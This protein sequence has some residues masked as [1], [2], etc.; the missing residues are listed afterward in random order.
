ML[1]LGCVAGAAACS[2]QHSTARPAPKSARVCPAKL[3]GKPPMPQ[4][5]AAQNTLAYWLRRYSPRELDETIL[6]PEDVARYDAAIGRRPGHEVYSQRD[7][8]VPVD[9]LL[10]ASDVRERLTQMQPLLAKHELVDATGQPLSQPQL[11]AFA[12]PMPPLHTSLRVVLAPAAM[13]CGPFDGSLYK[14][15]IEPAYDK[16]ACGTLQA[17]EVVELL[18]AN[19]GGLQLA[20]SRYSLGFLAADAKLSPAVPED[21]IDALVHG[22]RLYA[23]QDT[24]VSTRVAAALT[25]P[26]HATLPLLPSGQALLA[27]ASGFLR[28]AAP[29][30]LAATKRPLTRRA[31]LTAA[32]LFA[33]SPYGLGGARAGRDCSG[34]LVDIF[35]TFDL[36][37]PRYSG[38]QAEAGSYAVNLSGATET[39]KLRRLDLTAR[40]GVVLLHLPGH[41]MLYL[42]RSEAGVPMALHA[43]GD[44]AQPCDGGGESV[45][46]VQRTVVSTLDV[47][48]GSSRTAF[49]ERLDRLVVFARQPP[50]EL[51]AYLLPRPQ[52][53]AAPPA[54]A[55]QCKDDAETR[56][57]ITPALP[58]QG[59]P[60]RVIVTSSV[61]HPEALLQLYDASGAAVPIDETRLGGGGPPVTLVARLAKPLAGRY[62]AVLGYADTVLACRR[63]LLHETPLAEPKAR[64]TDP[65]WEPRWRWERD[66]E[67]LWSAFVEQLFMGPA[68]DEQTWTNLQSLLR[69]PSRNLLH[70]HLGLGEDD[71]LVIEPDCADLPYALRAYFA[72]KLKLP[73]AFRRCSRG[74]T[75]QPPTC[76]ELSSTFAERGE[77]DAVAAFDRFVNR[78][79]RSGVHSATGRTHPNDSATDLYPVAL[80]RSS[81]A[82]GTIYADPYG[83]VMM[84]SRWFA[85]ESIPGSHY[86]VL[87]AAEAQ[88][89]G[90]IGRRRFWQGSFLFDPSTES[91]GAGF[92]HFR[93]LSYDRQKREISAL[94]N[95]ALRENREFP[96]FSLEQYTGQKEDF[97]ERM[98]ALI[99]PTPLDPNERM[100]SLVDA[101]EEAVRRRVLAVDNGETF[102]RAHPRT[103]VEMPRGARIF[104][105]EG[106]WEDYATPSRDMR[107]LIAIDTVLALPERIEHKPERF[108][109][110][111][112]AESARVA[113][114]VRQ[115]LAKE[116]ASR[117]FT[118]T[119]SDGTHQPLTLMDV[120]SRAEALEIAY[121]PNECV[122]I[123][124]GAPEG[125]SERARCTRHAPPD[126][127]ARELAY[128][129][130]FHSR[131]RPARDE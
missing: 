104:E 56:I 49:L 38:W 64:P 65:I 30:T 76:G 97:Y 102:M 117:A 59:K 26:K 83:H 113:A 98:D 10:L 103:V 60:L 19:Q 33:D 93:P 84:I 71:R 29:A 122:E 116:L 28:V 74:R 78:D 111:A 62:T 95:D 36:A 129:R 53:S 24:P 41:I 91:V 9:P 4:V 66:T 22:P 5:S 128:R 58:L 119:R 73:Y 18:G 121:N 50:P 20:R 107:L 77:L 108:A 127:T 16:N 99:N 110:P 75:H 12:E 70:D 57:F 131:M 35:D 39:E 44:Y 55:A 13:R 8:S 106:A 72:W 43:L 14:L 90:T 82:P 63:V 126:Q 87:M 86:G 118:Y 25:L 130:W 120:T 52:P 51:S 3:A 115:A 124:W 109:L 94:D 7:L 85:Q 46:S 27:T 105:T 2:E 123:R 68:D 80:T 17:Q 69:D 37:L 67:N 34:L 100:R 31:V 48:R 79:V 6:G 89:D 47:G 40:T 15:P 21:L 61:S 114:Q 54:L 92:K 42:G 11:S 81:L 32:F 88:P 125:S 112:G 1:L 101:L 96:R 23:S 45:V